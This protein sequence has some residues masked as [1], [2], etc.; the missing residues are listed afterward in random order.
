MAKGI[1]FGRKKVSI[2]T[3]VKN[4]GRVNMRVK[5]GNI[6]KALDARMRRLR[7]GWQ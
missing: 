3:G 4:I 5:K 1:H 7:R 2:E 6:K